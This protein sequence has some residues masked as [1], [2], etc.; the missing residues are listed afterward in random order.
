MK[1]YDRAT[2]AVDITDRFDVFSLYIAKA[3]S[4]FGLVASREI[5]EKAIGVLPDRQARDMCV[6]FAD[7]EVRLMEVD[8]SRAIWSYGSQFADPRMDP[9]YWKLWQ[10]FEVK[11]GNEDTFKEML[12]WVF[13][14][15]V[16]LYL[17]SVFFYRIKRSV[18]AKFN[19]DVGYISAQLLAQRAAAGKNGTG[20][21][22]ADIA[23]SAAAMTGDVL[24][25]LEAQAAK[26]NAE[27]DEEDRLAG[28]SV[29]PTGA[30]NGVGGMRMVGFVPARAKGPDGKPVN[31]TP[32]ETLAEANGNANANP[33]EIEI[34]E[35]DEDDE[36]VGEGEEEEVEDDGM[37]EDAK[38]ELANIKQKSIP[39]AVFGGYAKFR[40]SDSQNGTEV[41]SSTAG[42]TTGSGI[43]SSSSSLGAKERFK[44][45]RE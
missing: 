44:R 39:D 17:P 35:D 12:R 10:D 2:S 21:D 8:R 3:V 38:K 37:D 40:N 32:E 4:F 23:L 7:L 11:Y 16:V 14:L 29:P 43:G 30:A 1:I 36:D 9:E 18:Q 13:S 42:A 24:K 25:N 28:R 41:S 27:L 33:D 34:D 5:Y 22:D 15:Y 45:K 19:S 26:L 20:K 6:R 31:P